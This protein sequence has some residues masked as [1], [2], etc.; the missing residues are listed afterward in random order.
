MLRDHRRCAR[1]GRRHVRRRRAHALYLVDGADFDA[2]SLSTVSTS[3]RSGPANT[4]VVVK[5][6]LNLAEGG[7]RG[8]G[9]RRLRAGPLE[10]RPAGAIVYRPSMADEREI[11][12]WDL[13]GI[14][15][16]ELSQQVADD[17]YEPEII[18]AIARGLLIAGAMATR[19]A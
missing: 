3:T 11:L 10:P 13:F 12:S 17:G 8:R 6:L 9:H 5:A 1:R 2:G 15:S 18:L 14:A 7:D 4:T 16:R 19:P